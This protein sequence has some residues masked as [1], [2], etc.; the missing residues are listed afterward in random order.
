[1]LKKGIRIIAFED[2]PIIKGSDSVLIVG[3]IGREEVI[4]GIISF[5]VLVDGSDATEN[6]ERAIKK[7]RFNNQTKMLV[8]NGITVA[9]LN[10]I[11]IERL[12]KGIKSP[13][14][15]ITRKRPNPNRLK[16]AIKVRATDSRDK[17]ALVN[18]LA[19]A[20]TIAKSGDFYTQTIG[21]NKK[22]ISTMLGKSAS[23]LRL[24]H[25]I[26]SGVVKGESKGRM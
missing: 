18:K 21:M 11:D 13:V 8:F 16:Y 22:E 23:L 19:K 20:M 1:M 25:L 6:I 17:T 14:L 4:E 2:S 24:A 3:V 5:K 26:A 12:A 15:A 9:G 10:I 7:S